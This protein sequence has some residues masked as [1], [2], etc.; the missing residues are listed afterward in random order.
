MKLHYS[1]T[2]FKQS[3]RIRKFDYHM[4]LHYSQTKEYLANG[5]Q[6]FDYHMKLHYSQTSA[7]GWMTVESDTTLKHEVQGAHNPLCLTTI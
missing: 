2:I 3:P 7:R 1:Q 5:K 4:K 6:K